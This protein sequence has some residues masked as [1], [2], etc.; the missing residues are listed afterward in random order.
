MGTRQHT[1]TNG[2]RTHRLGVATVD[3]RLSGQDPPAHRG[4][5]QL[6]DSTHHLGLV[7]SR[8]LAATQLCLGCGDGCID[9]GIAIHLVGNGV[10]IAQ[11]VATGR[12]D[13]RL[14]CVIGDHFRHC[15]DR[16]VYLGG[17]FLDRVDRHLHLLVTEQ[18]RTEHNLLGQLV[19]LRLDHQDGVLGTRNHQ[20]QV[21][22]LTQPGRSIQD[23]AAIL[24]ADPRGADRPLERCTGN[25]Q[26]G[27]CADQ[28]RDL[29][30]D[31]WI[32]R[33]Y[34]TDDLGLGDEVFRK[35]GPDRTVDQA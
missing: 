15:D 11:G 26:R 30:I 20:V 13:S 6:F 28:R 35:Q 29:G 7:E 33:L 1:G 22:V 9:G 27:R 18:H 4:L 12:F 31:T 8:G 2:D 17:Q 24:V 32:E 3:A 25:R 5:L 16:L 23:I 34:G 19:G 21:R 14:Q 10:G